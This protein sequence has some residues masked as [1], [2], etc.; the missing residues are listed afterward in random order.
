VIFD[1]EEFS[2]PIEPISA[3]EARH[4]MQERKRR[5]NQVAGSGRPMCSFKKCAYTDQPCSRRASVMYQ[6]KPY[7]KIHVK[8]A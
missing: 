7:C 8:M 2:I 1:W 5:K 3:A 6:G 4:V